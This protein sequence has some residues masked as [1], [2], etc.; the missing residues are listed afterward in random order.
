M[1]PPAAIRATTAI[2]CAVVAAGCSAGDPGNRAA[3]TAAPVSTTLGYSPTS[4]RISPTTLRA[5]S[6]EVPQVALEHRPPYQS[7]VLSSAGDVVTWVTDEVVVRVTNPSQNKIATTGVQVIVD[8]GLPPLGR[9]SNPNIVSIPDP[10]TDHPWN[11]FETID[12]GRSH[13]FKAK[14]PILT[15]GLRGARPHC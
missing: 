6:C 11:K 7:K 10:I 2:V 1:K 5:K 4:S 9:G 13:A 14:A 8:S 3:A 15:V 12:P